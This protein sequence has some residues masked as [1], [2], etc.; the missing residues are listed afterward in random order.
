MLR[1]ALAA[2][3]AALPAAPAAP[4]PAP[5][6]AAASQLAVM[7]LPQPVAEASL[8]VDPESGPLGRRAA[9]I[10]GAADR[11]E[12]VAGY[13]LGYYDTSA[14]P[15]T[16]QADVVRVATAVALYRDEAA[17]AR[18]L[19]RSRTG[20]RAYL[21]AYRPLPSTIVEVRPVRLLA[22]PALADGATGVEALERRWNVVWT[23]QELV[24]RRGRYLAL[25]RLE[26]RGPPAS[27][28]TLSI[29]RA[30]V[31]RIYAILAG[32]PAGKAVPIP[33]A[34]ALGRLGPLP[35]LPDLPYSMLRTR[36]VPGARVAG[37]KW[38]KDPTATEAYER[39]LRAGAVSGAQ[40]EVVVSVTRVFPTELAA[41]EALSASDYVESRSG[42]VA[43]TFASISSQL[44]LAGFHLAGVATARPHVGD[45]AVV[46]VA[47]FA[48]GARQLV[49]LTSYIRVGR[50]VEE[51]L[52]VGKP[53]AALD[54]NA[55]EW[56]LRTVLPRL[57]ALRSPLAA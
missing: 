20:A 34:V 13:E 38:I 56:L 24:V 33:P 47:R 4:A 53:G 39:V 49:F 7:V 28:A 5:R 27:G 3:A 44:G 40:V 1:V 19:E 11:V 32:R 51:V 37:Q 41:A 50:M 29:A 45:G 22:P 15:F 16:A 18:A 46:A 30:L 54:P 48:A 9:G 31:H 14:R 43:R 35:N 17:A 23:L 21:R 26:T 52:V 57:Q 25:A 10:L 55:G 36:D 42:L 2:F 8:R 6:P 12:R